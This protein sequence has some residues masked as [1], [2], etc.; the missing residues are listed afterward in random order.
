MKTRS[1][2]RS[3][4]DNVIQQVPTPERISEFKRLLDALTG[5][6]T[7]DIV[8]RGDEA[9]SAWIESVLQASQRLGIPIMVGT[10]AAGALLVWRRD[11]QFPHVPATVT[12]FTPESLL[13]S[14]TGIKDRAKLVQ[15]LT[16]A[17]RI[18][19][20]RRGRPRKG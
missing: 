14:V 6:K 13:A 10:N 1:I 4:L 11:A 15:K 20:R 17:R 12:R 18:Q 2:P 9:I 3:E 19:K 7:I 5:D 8:P 16:D